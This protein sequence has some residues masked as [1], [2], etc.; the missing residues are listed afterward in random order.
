M[1][2]ESVPNRNSPP[3]ILLRQSLRQGAKIV[4]HTLA[5]LSSWPAAQID[6]LRR[7]LK[8]ESLVAP[9]DAFHILRS[10]PHGHVAAALG[11]LR[12]LLLEPILSRSPGSERN[13]VVAM[14][15]A[16][17]LEPSSK[18]A[19]TRGL[20]PHTATSSLASVLGV[21]EAL[22]ETQLYRALDW[23]LARQK[24]IENALAKRHLSEGS[25]VLYDVSSTYFEGRCCPLARFGHSRDERSANPQIVFGLLTDPEG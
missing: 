16:R 14:I 21:D 3:A 11:T 20:H 23:L 19:T 17:I 18:L 10:A 5:N 15:V 13:L 8:G 1:Y 22:E 7:V 4:K 25:L 6:S 24:S 9:S 2:I 12:R